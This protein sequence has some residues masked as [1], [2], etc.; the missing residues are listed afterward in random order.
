MSIIGKT[1]KSLKKRFGSAIT[2]KRYVYEDLDTRTGDK[3]ETVTEC[4][5]SRGI[6]LTE[7]VF[8]KYFTKANITE[9]VSEV[10]IMVDANDC[11]FEPTEED[12]V[13]VWGKEQKLIKVEVL[14]QSIHEAYILHVEDVR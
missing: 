5:I 13:I 7:N 6:I 2:L 9:D 12:Y 3:L 8:D 14:G 11:T 1:I 4:A 10:M